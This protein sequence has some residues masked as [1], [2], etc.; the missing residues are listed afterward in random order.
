VAIYTMSIRYEIASVVL[1]PR[2]DNMTKSRIWESSN[3][4]RI[5]TIIRLLIKIYG[6]SD[7]SSLTPL[8]PDKLQVI[9]AYVEEADNDPDIRRASLPTKIAL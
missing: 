3:S 5:N 8:Y 6:D 1:L 9:G 7:K 2:K 4:N